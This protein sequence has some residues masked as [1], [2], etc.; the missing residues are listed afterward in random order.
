MVEERC[1]CAGDTIVSAVDGRGPGRAN[2]K[3]YVRANEG[4]AVLQTIKFQN[5]P[6]KEDGVNG[7]QNED[8]LKIVI[9]RL[10][11]FQT[12][13]YACVENEEALDLIVEACSRL[14]LRTARRNVRGVEGTSK[15]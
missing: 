5:G 9:D 12:G 4:G 10:I 6:V 2:H 13:E 1:L 14:N 11:G 7:V 15:K 8:L 3:Y